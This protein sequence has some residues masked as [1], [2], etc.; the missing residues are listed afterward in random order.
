MEGEKSTLGKSRWERAAGK[1]PLAAWH[2]EAAV[3]Q[4]KV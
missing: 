2:D 1:E 4:E 3:G